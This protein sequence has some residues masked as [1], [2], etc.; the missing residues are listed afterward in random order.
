MHVYLV[1]DDPLIRRMLTRMLSQAGLVSSE[2]ATA[3]DF[4]SACNDLDSGCVLMDIGMPG[5]SGLEAIGRLGRERPDLVVVMVSGSQAVDDA[6]RSFRG[7]AV[8]FLRKPF[9]NEELV[10]AV[11]EA[12]A[13]AS[14]RLAESERHRRAAGIR[15]SKREQQV[16]EGLNE[17]LQSKAMAWSMSLS[18]RTIE[19]HRSKLFTKLGARNCTQAVSIARELALIGGGA[20]HHRIGQGCA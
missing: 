4:L 17:G 19:M 6:I 10:S 11:Q 7:G 3:E 12:L 13:L 18:V 14:T 9:S 2:F 15:L 20:A 1:D 5:V 16:L 8:H